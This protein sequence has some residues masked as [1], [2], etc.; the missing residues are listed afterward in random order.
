MLADSNGGGELF[1]RVPAGKGGRLTICHA[2]PIASGF[3]RKKN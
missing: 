2:K 3:L 1:L